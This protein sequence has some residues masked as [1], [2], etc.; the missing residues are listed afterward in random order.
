MTVIGQ[1]EQKSLINQFKGWALPIGEEMSDNCIYRRFCYQAKVS[2]KAI[3]S[4]LPSLVM[5]QVRHA[6]V[7]HRIEGAVRHFERSSLYDRPKV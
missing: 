6:I 2:R 7:C 4:S 1:P 5:L 3:N